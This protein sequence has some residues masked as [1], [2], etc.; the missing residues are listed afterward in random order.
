VVVWGDHGWHLGDH[1]VWG[2]HTVFE[3]ALK[4]TLIMKIPGHEGLVTEKVVSTTDIYPTILELCK[5]ELPHEINGRS[6][7]KLLEN[8]E[9]DEWEDV[10]F[11]YF[12]NGIS[13]R[14]DRYRFTKYFRD[15]EPV[16]ELYDHKNDPYE[17]VNIAGNNQDLIDELIK[18]W[19]KGNTG[20]Y[21][22]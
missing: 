7:V 15:Q 17:T 14:T 20:L 10:A 8:P 12:N 3:R 22:K 11:S 13:L 6:M 9:S 16:L 5:I 19:S 2:K 4:S 21:G 18:V 1:L